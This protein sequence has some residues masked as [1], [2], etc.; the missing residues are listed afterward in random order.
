MQ[1]Q[2]HEN[3]KPTTT[4]HLDI[5]EKKDPENNQEYG[6]NKEENEDDGDDN[7]KN[8]GDEECE[9]ILGDIPDVTIPPVLQKYAALLRA[10]STIEGKSQRKRTAT[11]PADGESTQ[12]TQ[13]NECPV[14]QTTA[15]G[16]SR[17]YACR[18]CSLIFSKLEFLEAHM[19]RLHPV[20]GPF[21]NLI[22][23]I[24][25]K[26]MLNLKKLSWLNEIGYLE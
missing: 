5:N 13:G 21:R 9:M 10:N 25:E 12:I 16:T 15:S 14:G 17:R 1:D 24:R 2:V 7:S 11:L 19:A 6:K 20:V 22:L 26:G 18:K 8:D 23:Q 4:A 3:H